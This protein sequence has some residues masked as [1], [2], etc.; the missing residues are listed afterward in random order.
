[1]LLFVLNSSLLS[2]R[3][4]AHLTADQASASGTITVDNITGFAV[5]KY[6]LIGE[7]GEPTS[8]IIRIHTST[9]PTGTTVTLASNTVFDHY[10]GA[11]VTM[12]DYNQVEFSRA[13]TLTGA[14]SVLSTVT[15]SADRPETIYND[16][17][18]STGYGF[19]RFKNSSDSIYSD[20][21]DGVN[22][23]GADADSFG[24]LATEG[25]NLVGVTI[26]SDYA[27]EAIL[28][29]DVNACLREIAQKQDWSFEVVTDTTS[30][31]TTEN[32]NE[33]ALSS[34]TYPIKHAISNKAVLDVR[35]GTSKPL[36]YLSPD[37]M[38]FEFEGVKHG[39]LSSAVTAG[40]TSVTLTDSY[41][42]NST[43]GTISLGSN[44]GVAYTL[45]TET[46]GV[47]SGISASAITTNVSAGGS[48][49][50]GVNP[51]LPTKYTIIGK[52]IIFNVPIDTDYVGQ[53]IKIRYLKKLDTISTFGDRV[54][55]AFFNAIPLYIAY[56]IETRKRNFDVAK[57]FYNQFLDTLKDNLTT[58]AAPTMDGTSYY[59]F[60]YG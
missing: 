51:G 39:Y 2:E 20:Y 10:A 26:G 37:D 50:Q 46:T 43:A 16:L 19:V 59:K 40:D 47:L 36:E 53:K 52:K 3:E 25:C 44:N 8:E 48:V 41:E 60:S 49:W 35:I 1:M 13:T 15:V 56:R 28:Y 55:V 58:Y 12:I 32:E 30:L 27:T 42:F 18:N 17:T 14:K 29:K 21:S 54:D 9:A 33:F 7:F 34:L 57:D 11:K 4:I 5:G 24:E 31:T 23:T 38:D 6:I 22:Y 45:N